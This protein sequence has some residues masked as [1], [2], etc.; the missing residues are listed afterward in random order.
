MGH[1]VEEMLEKAK[2]RGYSITMTRG[3][4]KWYSFIHERYP[5]NLGLTLESGEFTLTHLRGI[6]KISTGTCGSFMNDAHFLRIQRE[7]ID[8]IL[9]VGY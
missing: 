8:V 7:I 2:E 4:R 9:K 6:I 1:T 3:D 5:I